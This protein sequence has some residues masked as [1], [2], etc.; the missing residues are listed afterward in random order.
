MVKKSLSPEWNEKFTWKFAGSTDLGA[1]GLTPQLQWGAPAYT[2]SRR[3]AAGRYL[4]I[5][6]WDWDRITRNDFMGALAFEVQLLLVWS[7][8]GRCCRGLADRYSACV[9]PIV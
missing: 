8:W 3:T 9:A 5:E 6:V 1:E 7:V 2:A 4:S